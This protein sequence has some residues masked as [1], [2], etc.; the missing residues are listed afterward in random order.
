MAQAKAAALPIITTAHGAGLD[1]VTPGQDGWIVPVREAGRH[2]RA[3][4]L[5]RREPRDRRPRCPAR[6]RHVPAARLAPG[7]R[8]FRGRVPPGDAR[9]CRGA[10]PCLTETLLFWVVVWFLAAVWILARHWRGAGA[11]LV[12]TYVLTLAVMHWLAPLIY[13]LAVVRQS[14]I[15]PDGRGTAA[16]HVRHSG[17]CRRRRSHRS[18]SRD[19]ITRA[20]IRARASL[21]IRGSLICILFT[22]IALY[23]VV[24]PLAGRLPSA[25]ALVSTGSTLAVVAIGLKC[26]NAWT[27]R[28]SALLWAWLAATMTMPLVTVVGQGFLGYGFAAML[29]VFS[30]VASFFRP[31]WKVVVLATVLGF[32]GLSVYVN[33]MRDRRRDPGGRLV[34]RQRAGTAGFAEDH[35]RDRRVV[36]PEERGASESH[37]HAA[38]PGLPDRRRRRPISTAAPPSM[39]AAT[40]L[41]RRWPRSSRARS[42]RTNPSSPAAANWCRTYTGIRFIDGTSVGIGQMMESYV[43]FGSAG[44]A[45]CFLILGAALTWIESIRDRSPPVGRR[46]RVSPVVSARPQ[47]LADRWVIHGSDVDRG[48]RAHRRDC[49]ESA[50]RLSPR[51]RGRGRGRERGRDAGAIGGH[52]RPGPVWP[53][54]R[55]SRKVGESRWY[56]ACCGAC[57][58]IAGVTR[59][60]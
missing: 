59:R 38:E 15:R 30:F 35:L 8:G 5:V 11:G 48:R 49:V 60:G 43:N 17:I 4:D 25:T 22:G 31:R 14:A 44:V 21:W 46:Q 33:Y 27:R 1:I 6:L 45:S 57:S 29:T 37:R 39:A 9:P 20:R 50:G 47:P 41:V 12:F 52:A 16:E 58:P 42:G 2:R 40:T 54:S 32:L 10:V 28:T 19:G 51:P 36:R 3:A 7:C 56:P 53:R 13:L 24:F 26:W 55:S 34:G 23:G 18:R